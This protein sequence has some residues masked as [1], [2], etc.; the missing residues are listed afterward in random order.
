MTIGTK[1]P[2]ILKPV[3]MWNSVDVIYLK[4]KWTTCPIVSN[5]ADSAYF[6]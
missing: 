5:A 4:D 1:K 2:E 3:V 6:G